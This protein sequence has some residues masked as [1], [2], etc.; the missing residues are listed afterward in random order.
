LKIFSSSDVCP[1]NRE[2]FFWRKVYMPTDDAAKNYKNSRRV[3]FI[4]WTQT[5]EIKKIELD[6][7]NLFISGDQRTP[8]L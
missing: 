6:H 1:T 4:G 7:L 5:D 3:D 2:L 8:S